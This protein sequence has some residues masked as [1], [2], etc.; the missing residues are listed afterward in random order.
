VTGRVVQ[1]FRISPADPQVH[2]SLGLAFIAAGRVSDAIP[3]F[4][5]T[6]RLDPNFLDACINLTKA[7][8]DVGR[9]AD[10]ITTAERALRLAESQSRPDIAAQL[11]NWL[12]AH[13]PASTT[14]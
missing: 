6:L 2:N 5:S 12:R 13:R 1:A 14:R 4:E 3:H 9:P 8:S 11:Q 7:Y 10:A